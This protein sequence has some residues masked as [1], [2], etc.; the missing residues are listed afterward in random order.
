MK[1]ISINNIESQIQDLNEDYKKAK[2][3]VNVYLG[4]DFLFLKNGF[5]R[6]YI[7]YNSLKY[8]F[9]RVMVVPIG[10]KEIQVDY[11]IIADKRKELAQIKLA[12][13]K[14]AIDIIEELKQKAPNANF[15]CPERIK[16]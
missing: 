12:G 1:F 14:V 6:Y 2:K 11:L 9:R 10:K 5:N 15:T 7:S 16:R 13:R 4:D 8:A 3:Y